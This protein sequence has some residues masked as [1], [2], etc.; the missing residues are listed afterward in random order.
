MGQSNSRSKSTGYPYQGPQFP[1][2]FPPPGAFATLNGQ[3]PA[4]PG[5]PPMPVAGNQHLVVPYPIFAQQP[6][7]KRRTK[8]RRASAND[9]PR[10]QTFPVAHAPS[11]SNRHT[12]PAPASV[13]GY[14]TF[15]APPP[16][17][18]T[19]MANVAGEPLANFPVEPEIPNIG[20]A[21][22]S[23]GRAQ[24][25]YHGPMAPLDSSE[26]DDEM[27]PPLAAPVMQSAQRQRRRHT[28]PMQQ[29]TERP[30]QPPDPPGPSAF[31]FPLRSPSSNPLP[32]PP[33]DL[34]NAEA[35][36]AVLDIPRGTDL[37]TALYGYQRDQTQQQQ[38]GPGSGPNPNLSGNPQRTR[39]GLFGRKNS[40]AGGGL[41]RSL[42][43]TRGRR[44]EGGQQQ[45][46]QQP[47]TQEI[48]RERIRAGDVKLVPFPVPVE[49]FVPAAEGQGQPPQGAFTHVPPSSERY[50]PA[51]FGGAELGNENGNILMGESE[52]IVPNMMPMPS[53]EQEQFGRTRGAPPFPVMQGPGAAA[54]GANGDP[55]SSQINAPFPVMT[56]RPSSSAAGAQQPQPRQSVFISDPPPQR[57]RTPLPPFIFTQSSQAYQGFFPHSPHR[58]IYQNQSYPTAT[59]LHEALK[60]LPARPDITSSIRLCVNLADVY[61]L[62]AANMPSVRSDWGQL[63]FPGAG[64]LTSTASDNWSLV[65]EVCERA[66]SSEGSARAA[67][68]ALRRELR[69]GSPAVQLSA[70]RLWEIMLRNSSGIFMAQCNQR[71][72][73]DTLED[74]LKTTDAGIFETNVGG[75]SALFEARARVTSVLVAAGLPV[76]QVLHVPD[77]ANTQEVPVDEVEVVHV[78]TELERALSE[79]DASKKPSAAELIV[80]TSTDKPAFEW[81]DVATTQR[82]MD[83]LQSKLDSS[84]SDRAIST[85]YLALLRYLSKSFQALPLSLTVDD[86]TLKD[87]WPV[88]GGG[89]A[90]IYRGTMAD[91]Y[92]VCLKVLRLEIE[93]NVKERD[94]IRKRFLNE[95]LLWRQ[96]QHRN[97]LPLLGINTALFPLSCCLAS[98]WLKNGNIISYLKDNPLLDISF[99]LYEI[100]AGMQYLHHRDVPF[101]HGDIRGGNI[102]ITDKLH[103]RLADFGLTLVTPNSHLTASFSNSVNGAIRWLAPEYIDFVGESAPPNHT[104]RDVYAFGCTILEIL[105]LKPPFHGHLNDGSVIFKLMSGGRPARPSNV[106]CSDDIW[107][108]TTRCWAQNA[109]DRPS[110]LEIFEILEERI[111][112]PLT[113]SHSSLVSLVIFLRPSD[114]TSDFVRLSLPDEDAYD[115]RGPQKE[116]DI[117]ALGSGLGAISASASSQSMSP[118]EPT[119]PTPL[120]QLP[121]FIFTHIPIYQYLFLDS[122]HPIVYRNQSYPTAAHLHSAL[123]FL[124]FHPEIASKIRFSANMTDVGELETANRGLGRPDWSDV[125]LEEFEMVLDLKFSQHPDLRNELIMLDGIGTGRKGEKD[126]GGKGRRIVWRDEKDTFWGDGGGEG[127]G[128]NKLGK[129]LERVRDRLL[130]QIERER[131]V[132]EMAG[133]RGGEIETGGLTQKRSA[134]DALQF[135]VRKLFLSKAISTT[136][137][138]TSSKS[139]V[140]PR[141]ESPAMY[142]AHIGFQQRIQ[143]TVVQPLSL[144]NVEQTEEEPWY[145]SR[146]EPES[147]EAGDLTM[148]IGHLITTAS[149]DWNLMLELCEKVSAN[150]ANAREAAAA[151][152][153]G[154][155]YGLPASQL[156]AARLWEILLCNSSDEFVAR[157]TERGFLDTV[158][159]WLEK[160]GGPLNTGKGTLPEVQTRVINALAAAGNHKIHHL[161]RM[162]YT[163]APSAHEMKAIPMTVG[164]QLECVLNE[165]EASKQSY[166]AGFGST[167]TSMASFEWLDVV[168]AQILM[169][170]L[171]Q[172]SRHLQNMLHYLLIPLQRL[173]ANIIDGTNSKKYL[174][175]LRHLSKS[176]QTL[177]LS[178]LVE[179]VTVMDSW[180]I[181]GGGFAN[182]YRGTMDNGSTVCLKVL[183]LEVEQ[184]VNE[185]DKRYLNE[186]LLWRQLKHHNILPLLGVNTALF[187]HSFCLVSPW[188]K[189]GNI[190]S[191]LKENPGLDLSLVL[192]EIAAGMQYLHSRDVPFVHGDIRGGNILVT[193]ALHCRLADFGLTLVTP[194]SHFTAS[195]SNSVTGA[196]RWLAPEYIDFMGESAPPNHTSRDVYAFGCT[197]LEILTL[198]P[199]FQGHLNDASVIFKLM[200]GGRPA[201]PLDVWYPDNIWELTTQC[202]AHNAEDRPSAKDIFNILDRRIDLE[203]TEMA[204]LPVFGP[205]LEAGPLSPI[206]A[207]A[208]RQSPE[209][210]FTQ[211]I[212]PR[213]LRNSLP[214]FIFTTSSPA[215]QGFVPGSPHRVF[216]QFQ[217]Y[218]TAAHLH[219]ALKY[220]PA[221]PDIASEISNVSLADVYPLS[222]R[223]EENMRSDWPQV[224]VKEMEM[225][226]QLKFSQHPS[227]RNELIELDRMATSLAG[228]RDGG[229]KRRKIIFRNEDMFWGDGQGE[230]ENQLGKILGRVRDKML[231][232]YGRSVAPPS[233]TAITAGIPL[234]SQT[235]ALSTAK[236]TQAGFASFA[237]DMRVTSIPPRM[238]LYIAPLKPPSPHLPS[239]IFTETSS[240][241]YQGFLPHSPHHIRYQ[242]EIFPTAAHLFESQK[243]LPAHPEIASSI[244]SCVDLVDLGRSQSANKPWVRNDW[245]DVLLKELE[246]ILELKFMQHPV[247][248]NALILLDGLGG[249]RREI[250]FRNEDFFWGDGG[251]EGQG[252]NELG[253]ILGRVRDSTCT[254]CGKRMKFGIIIIQNECEDTL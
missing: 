141:H 228:V 167:T 165:W 185:R 118:R 55:G 216:Y 129:I 99:V 223:Y 121:P 213:Q 66:S 168:T 206:G 100:A 86:I 243:Y 53:T 106:R 44:Q 217:T 218:P 46:H 198:K 116:I 82:L 131:D 105:T 80:P 190:I 45:S 32:Q 112:P 92:T 157:C 27:V 17:L 33:R 214:P 181:A 149:E 215:Y 1:A 11:T 199:P 48:A 154:F 225:V 252:A 193:D 242:G 67:A 173:D 24:T 244:R 136:V 89:F 52:D 35:Y 253:K 224:L 84:I 188:M 233:L 81:L 184:N 94:K 102:L 95:A 107:D 251:G 240:L 153:K 249:E 231:E 227:L 156:S 238:Q 178:L 31:D 124:P 169:D 60:Y 205:I 138:A 37:F 62:S 187:R 71:G 194:S 250:I 90:N 58:I 219:E 145:L 161:S 230:G 254:G 61:P 137:F 151:L 73:L 108:L 174:A 130:R 41:F 50:A 132:G 56:A 170:S 247:L 59:H 120:S 10:Q 70:A 75:K 155:K 69:F 36:R 209:P 197:I 143:H 182:I 65:L 220:L 101:V 109:Q 235:N 29:P 91:E 28:V 164:Q 49:R 200:N 241:L 144:S 93:Q 78:E 14:R 183:R 18:F 135:K 126:G 162:A 6:T 177:P 111:L 139:K 68:K 195:S 239:F 40:K 114:L 232:D 222:A 208:V 76:D 226:L 189:N 246:W 201:R 125:F 211:D 20:S 204:N 176:F 97:I 63:T 191:Y 96:L 133:E 88:A 163:E 103:C 158:E 123:K 152:R 42:T 110:A 140:N 5:Y 237:T 127:R 104:S 21:P 180:P 12:V 150:E 26:E 74:W 79:W 186:A 7:Q 64:H 119:P 13:A 115:Y 25:P 22:P 229:G 30:F 51:T 117:T 207:P 113:E 212:L 128:A 57:S 122:P 72:F 38:P 134:S 19:P 172:A 23:R 34:F 83:S 202:W 236:T 148:M 146:E 248:K 245:D 210:L 43:G 15:P 16:P 47:V 160:T 3:Y 85:K 159:D 203:H 39:M 87:S 98:P 175:L 9:A 221:Q 147:T 171:Q 77:V 234:P 179:G 54:A 166:T 8:R 4:Y 142:D 2:P 196:I 192:Y